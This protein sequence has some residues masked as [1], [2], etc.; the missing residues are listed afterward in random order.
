MLRIDEK[1]HP[2]RHVD[3]F[4]EHILQM[5]GVILDPQT[6]QNRSRERCSQYEKKQAFASKVKAKEFAVD[7]SFFVRMIK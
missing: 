7:N 2:G 4:F 5:L 1:L 3:F 6:T